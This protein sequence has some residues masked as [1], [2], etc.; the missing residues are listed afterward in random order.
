[1]IKIHEH[2]IEETIIDKNGWVLD[3]GCINFEFS[4][5]LKKYCNN[6][7]CVDP[8]PNIKDIPDGIFF[9]KAALISGDTTE[10][11]YYIY[12]DIQGFSLLNPNQD[13]CSLID[14]IKIPSINF[15]YIMDK[16]NIE[17][18]EL[19]KFDIEGSEYDILEKMDWGIT[20]QI[21]VEFHDF[22]N[23]NPRYPNN[24]KYYTDLL[25]NIPNNYIV[26]QHQKTDH[27]GFPF[28][29]GLNYWDSLFIEKI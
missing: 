13:W 10:V 17:K 14:K 1:M 26:A 24:E 29:M 2:T 20:K 9:E 22:R 11:D 6:I 19:I 21:S 5:G 25:N 8:N 3:L 28:G 27:P 4:L 16:Y 18:F 15:K 23:M 7:I 12:N